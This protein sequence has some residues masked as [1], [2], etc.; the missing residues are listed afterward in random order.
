MLRIVLLL[1]IVVMVVKFKVVKGAQEV[2]L[3]YLTSEGCI[4]PPLNADETPQAVGVIMPPH[5]NFPPTMFHLFLC[6]PW[7]QVFIR[8]P[9]TPLHPIQ[10]KNLEFRL[11]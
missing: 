5:C 3:Q 2:L 6:K 10:P 7:V 9:P 1:E 8:L 11:V 4:H